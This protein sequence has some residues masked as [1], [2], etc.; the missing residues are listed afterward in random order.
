MD[1][2]IPTIPPILLMVLNFLSPYIVSLLTSYEATPKA[3][4]IVAILVSFVISILVI[5]IALWVGWI[6]WD[7][8]PIGIVTLI[9][10]G[11]LLQ[12]VAFKNFIGTS[13]TAIMKTAG[14]GAIS[15]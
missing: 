12:Q 5:V 9:V 8:S 7:G 14:V 2:V 11:L 13:A 1:W 6:P 4:K 15:S 10:I 3:K